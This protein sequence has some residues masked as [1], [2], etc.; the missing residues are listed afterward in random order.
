MM[1]I[2]IQSG[3]TLVELLVVIVVIS[4]LSMIVVP[5]IS[6]TTDVA[7]NIHCINNLRNLGSA[8]G[9]YLSEND[10]EF[11]PMLMGQNGVK[12]YF[13][14][15]VTD[16]VDPSASPLLSAS[17]G[18]LS[19]MWCPKQPWGTYVPQGNVSEPTTNYGY[20]AW[21]L[22]PEAWRRKTQ[23]GVPMRR[24]KRMDI[25]RPGELFV[26]ADSAMHCGSVT[27][28]A[29]DCSTWRSFGRSH[30]M[31]GSSKQKNDLRRTVL[32]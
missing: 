21:C 13:W 5:S 18:S 17:G 28:L 8:M 20:N 2:K 27:S 29:R 15:T 3:F 10:D 24:K 6:K 1:R 26:F 16:P 32:S 12:T 23:S 31:T 14:G 7:Y 4:L 25:D 9:L 11:W 30:S 19:T 22:D